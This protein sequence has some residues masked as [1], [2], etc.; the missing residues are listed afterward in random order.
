MSGESSPDAPDAL[1]EQLAL[2]G[3]GRRPRPARASRARAPRPAAADRPVASVRVDSVVPHLDRVFDYAVP[4]DLDSHIEVGRRVRVRFSGRLVDGLVV[5]RSDTGEHEGALRPIERVIGVESVLTPATLALVEAVAERYAGTFTDVLRSAVPP[6]HA[7]AESVRITPAQWRAEAPSADRWEMYEHG[8]ALLTHVAQESPVRAAW[9]IAPAT[10]APQRSWAAHVVD[11]VQAATSGERG[12]VIV[13]VPD[14]ADVDRMRAALATVGPELPAP[15]VLTAD[16]GPERRYREFVTVLRGGARVVV[17]TRASVFAPMPSLRL[18][19]VWDDG[20]DAL[21]EPHAPYWHA[22]DVAALRSHQEGCHLVVGSPARTPALQQWCAT[23]WAR[24][25]APTR[26]TLAA[27]APRV[28]ALSEHDQARDPAAA[29]ARI[30]HAAW[31]V[32]K[33]ALALGPVLVQVARRGYVAGLACQRCREV[34]RCSCG[35]PLQQAAGTAPACSWCGRTDWTCA[36]CGGSAVRAFGIGAERTA[37]EIGR[38]FPGVPVLSS[39]AGH[40]LADVPHRSGIVVATPGA[41]PDC[42]PGYAAVLCLDARAMLERPVLDAGVDA[43]HRWMS[44]ARL[45]VPQAPVVV[46]ADNALAP[47][48]ALVRWDAPWLA[49]REVRERTAAGLPPA[50]RMASLTGDL[51]A[52]R[53]VASTLQ[54]A[55]RIL[56]PVPEGDQQRALI[57]VDREDA[58]ALAR[59]LRGITAARS[60][61]GDSV[62]RIVIDPLGI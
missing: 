52:V 13:V 49:E 30:P 16:Q 14:A 2:A 25:I 62:V 20:N 36:S 54:V 43:L 23:G 48:Q 1:P 6:R 56:G 22:T 29:A 5:A 15:A 21:V 18:I 4:A 45:A 55:H 58:L 39:H 12:G 40:V 32:A 53:A 59:D 19:V 57:V 26:A 37:E 51:A 35:G 11:L 61:R 41:E 10:G 17:G 34:A 44:A 24:S 42:N 33:E 28:R 27:N 3:V 38:A 60:V 7:R 50:T 8:A 31:Q 46:T 9:S 47:V